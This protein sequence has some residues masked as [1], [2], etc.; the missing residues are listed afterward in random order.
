MRSALERLE[1]LGSTLARLA[2]D[3]SA[4]FEALMAAHKLPRDT[5]EQQAE[6]RTVIQAATAQ[7][8]Q[9]PLQVARH[10]VAILGE[11]ATLAAQGNSNA[12]T[13]AQVGAYLAH[14]ACMGALANVH[15]NLADLED[16]ALVAKIQAEAGQLREDATARL[17]AIVG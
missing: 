5:D 7:A 4:A 3:D 6:R 8:S 11:L 16:A 10:S 13:D 9:I 17:N 12:R 14:A 2:S 1:L 15:V